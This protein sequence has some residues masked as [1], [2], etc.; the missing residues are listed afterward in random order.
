MEPRTELVQAE[1]IKAP[2]GVSERLG[3]TEDDQTL[4]RK[5]H[6][7]ANERP[8]Q[9]AASYIPLGIAGSVDL[10]FPDTGPTGIYQRL[11]ER[12]HCVVRFAEERLNLADRHWKKLSSFGS[13]RHS[14]FLKLYALPT[15][16]L[17][18]RL[19]L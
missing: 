6:M 4:I 15:T 3:L 13:A 17:G 5:R 10:A 18:N 7:F 11:A 14:M 1:L 12:G 2:S 9:L 8:V 19:R 16:G